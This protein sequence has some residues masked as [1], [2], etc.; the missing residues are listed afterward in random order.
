MMTTMAQAPDE[1]EVQGFGLYMGEKVNAGDYLGEYK[2]EIVTKEEGSR[3]GAVYQHLRTNY[4]FDLNKAQ[5]VDSTRAG[6][7]LRFINNSAKS[8]NCEPRVMLCN[9]I[10]RIG[11]FATKD[12]KAGEELFFNYNYP[13][14]VTQHFWE[15]G[16]KAGTAVAVRTKK[17]KPKAKPALSSDSEALSKRKTGK[18]GKAGPSQKAKEG[19]SRLGK[20]TL[21]GSSTINHFAWGS[22]GK[23]PRRDAQKEQQAW[24]R[25]TQY[26]DD[27]ATE[28][29]AEAEES[30]AETP[31]EESSEDVE[32][33]YPDS[34]EDERPK[35]RGR[36]AK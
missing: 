16:Q 2:G 27:D 29:Q 23:R 28:G 20:S 1:S 32:V 34:E 7:K 35:K 36:R 22:P 25:L 3:R 17:S 15:K 11:M 10:V 13:E 6:N 4:L 21:K 8:P 14:E 31:D 24:A 26:L 33:E 18:S 9:T 19:R 12:I 30:D 5:E